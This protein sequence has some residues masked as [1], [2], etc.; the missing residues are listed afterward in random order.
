MEEEYAKC[1]TNFGAAHIAA[2]EAS[3]EEDEA[4]HQRREEFDLLAAERGRVAMLQEQRKRDREAE[5][6]IAKKKR[7]N[8]KSVS[9]QADIVTRRQIG[10]DLRNIR[11]ESD[12]GAGESED[13]NVGMRVEKFKNKP[14]LH[15]SHSAGYNPK[16]YTSHSIDSSNHAD[17]DEEE[18][19]IEVDSEVEFNQISNLL[20]QKTYEFHRDPPKSVAR[21]EEIISLSSSDSE[22]PPRPPPQRQKQVKLPVEQPKSKGI[23]KNPPKKAQKNDQ[24]VNYVDFGNKYV[25]SYIPSDDLVTQNTEKTGSNAKAAAERHEKR[26]KKGEVSDEVLR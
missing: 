24:R 18:S 22:P 23:L 1:L 12:G 25:S 13:E 17:S 10:V 15:K 2:C 3:C 26:S 4:I 21:Q 20:K 16:D 9:V 6:R 7:K 8:V 14:N 5:E 19:S 11:E